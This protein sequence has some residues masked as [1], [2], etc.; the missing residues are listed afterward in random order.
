MLSGYQKILGGTLKEQVMI[1]KITTFLDISTWFWL[2]KWFWIHYLPKSLR[3]DVFAI[4]N[5]VVRRLMTP[6]H[7]TRA[8]GPKQVPDNLFWCSYCP[9]KFFK[10][11]QTRSVA[12]KI[13]IFWVIFVNIWLLKSFRLLETTKSPSSDVFAIKNCLKHRP[14]F[15]FASACCHRL[16]QVC[17]NLFW[18]LQ[19]IRTFLR[20]YKHQ[21]ALFK[22]P[23]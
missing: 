7:S 13:F 6:L 2:W 10:L 12:F 14:M 5:C 23:C 1:C 15:S 8:Q 4:K 22:G 9:R 20:A 18:C 21:D 17:N 11:S 3:G 19:C 16:V